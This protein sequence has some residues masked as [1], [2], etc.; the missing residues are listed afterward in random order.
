MVNKPFNE[1]TSKLTITTPENIKTP[2]I[3]MPKGVLTKI[4][5]YPTVVIL[6]KVNHIQLPKFR[7]LPSK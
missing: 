6:S 1:E 3:N 5:P 2:S 7:N 4:S